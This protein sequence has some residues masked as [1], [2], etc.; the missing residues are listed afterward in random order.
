M[1]SI[2]SCIYLFGDLFECRQIIFL[3]NGYA[4]IDLI[5]Q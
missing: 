2:V 3:V 1:Q 4:D 5:S